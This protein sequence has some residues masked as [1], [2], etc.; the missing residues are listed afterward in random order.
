M[1]VS[2]SIASSVNE[3]Y[4]NNPMLTGKQ[5]FISAMN[6]GRDI[7]G[8]MVNTLILAFAGGALPTM[9]MIWGYNMEYSQ[10]INI[11]TIVIEIVNALAGSIGIIAT[12]P[13]T[14]AISILLINREKKGR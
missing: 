13:L 9:M 12:V 10:F 3:I 14:G 6:I 4:E 11:P 2:M 8:T 5:L 1:D 7:M